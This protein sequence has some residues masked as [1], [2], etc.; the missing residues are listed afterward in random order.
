MTCHPFQ[1]RR[2]LSKRQDKIDATEAHG[3]NLPMRYR[4]HCGGSNHTIRCGRLG[5]AA[6][7]RNTRPEWIERVAITEAKEA[8][9]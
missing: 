3:E 8:E 1:S 5:L 7:I 9:T 2:N 6:E 4:I